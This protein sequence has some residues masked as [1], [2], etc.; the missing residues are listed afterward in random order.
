MTA[1]ELKETLNGFVSQPETCGFEMYLVSKNEK[2]LWRMS[3][4]QSERNNLRQTLRNLV[5][6]V[7]R[8]KY[9]AEGVEYAPAEYVADNQNKFYL[10]EQGDNYMPFGFVRNTPEAF[11]TDSAVDIVGLVFALRKGEQW[12][13]CY[14]NARSITV[15]NRK[16]MNVVA[17][18]FEKEGSVYFEEQAEPIISIARAIDAVVIENTVITDDIKM[19][20][21]NFAFDVF[22]NG[23]AT[24]C[25]ESI[26]EIDLVDNADKLSDYIRRGKRTYA[27]KMMRIHNSPVMKM[28]AG[29]LIEK[30]N[31][32][33]RW[34]GRFEFT[35]EGKIQLNTYKQVESLIDLFDERYTRSDIS[36]TEYDTGVKKEAEPVEREARE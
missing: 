7:L 30:I 16:K 22:I 35:P 34:K 9:L 17:R 20:E 24:A 15:P 23:R 10:I 21:R 33:E 27:R 32:V 1:T 13:Y 29:A 5:F 31:T 3:L 25:V 19:M 2:K 28:A 11:E 6:E 4:S 8:S 26:K 36:G 18:F 12:I 14:Q